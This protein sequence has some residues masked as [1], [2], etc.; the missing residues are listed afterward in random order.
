MPRLAGIPASVIMNYVPKMHPISGMACLSHTATFCLLAFSLAS[1]ITGVSCSQPCTPQTSPLSHRVHAYDKQPRQCL[2]GCVSAASSDPDVVEVH[3]VNLRSS[4]APTS[5]SATDS[6]SST[7]QNLVDFHFK[8]KQAGFFAR[9]LVFVLNSAEPVR[10]SVEGENMLSI[11]SFTIKIVVPLHSCQSVSWNPGI[12]LSVNVEC[13]AL[14]HNNSDLLV[15]TQTHYGSVSTFSEVLDANAISL[16]VG[17][18]IT[19]PPTCIIQSDFQTPDFTARHVLEQPITGCQAPNLLGPLQPEFHVVLLGDVAGAL[20]TDTG[21]PPIV[22]LELQPVRSTDSSCDIILVLVSEANATWKV[23][24]GRRRGLLQVMTPNSVDMRQDFMNRVEEQ[25]LPR[26]T[27]GLMAWAE[28][29]EWPLTSFTSAES[30]NEFIISIEHKN[31]PTRE[32]P[33]RLSIITQYTDTDC[34][35][36]GITVRILRKVMDAFDL[37]AGNMMLRD[38]SCKAVESGDYYVIDTHRDQCGTTMTVMDTG[39][40]VYHN[41][42]IYSNA[43]SVIEGSGESDLER[44][45]G[46]LPVD[47]EQSLTA[48]VPFTCEYD[49][50][51]EVLTS[52]LFGGERKPTITISMDMYTGNDFAEKQT[53]FPFTFQIGERVY[54]EVALKDS[55]QLSIVP[56]QCWLS[57]GSRALTDNLHFLIYNGCAR[58]ET[59][60]FHR[61]VSTSGQFR[62]FS[63]D[64]PDLQWDALYYI[65]CELGICSRDGTGSSRGIPVCESIMDPDTGCLAINKQNGLVLDFPTQSLYLGPY[66]TSTSSVLPQNEGT[67]VSKG[68]GEIDDESIDC[69]AEGLGTGPAA[70]IAVASFV[71]GMVL[72]GALWFIHT[73]TGPHTGPPPSA[74]PCTASTASSPSANGHLMNGH[75]PNGAIP[76]GTVPS[77][78][79]PNGHIPAGFM[80]SKLNP[81]GIPLQGMRHVDP[82][83]EDV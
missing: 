4:T 77:G 54:F 79:I 72:M 80:A 13:A 69:E 63:Y 11:P 38:H 76:N 17:S 21:D 44:L 42:V 73:H 67:I 35:R 34:R 19:S 49:S 45:M 70:A 82:S 48:Q 78:A 15:F 50:K 65:H 7:P 8:P 75:I 33:S 22:T 68:P 27:A 9:S 2:A 41:E 71:M 64:V 46:G 58:D 43:E 16:L 20:A 24:P 5:T 32:P 29:K 1:I 23:N 12:S 10:W 52:G 81:N 83:P 36:D 55:L 61:D 51:G 30:A 74:S 40:V 3:V 56:S 39:Q 37:S 62:R 60:I 57:P 53:T 6:E 14:P 25:E 66:K 59:L 47:D 31:A 26:N 28:M 18:G